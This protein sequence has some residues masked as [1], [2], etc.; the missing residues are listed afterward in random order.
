MAI[1]AL[2]G[3]SYPVVRKAL[4]LYAAGDV[5]ALKRRQR[6]RSLIP[7]QEGSVRPP[8]SATSVPSS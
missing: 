2:T 6:G 4:D 5:A 8:Q 1:V 7:E 3:L